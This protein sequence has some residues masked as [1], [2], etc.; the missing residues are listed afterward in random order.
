MSFEAIWITEHWIP[1][2]LAI[3]HLIKEM[4]RFSMYLL[5]SLLWFREV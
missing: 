4:Y 3:C 5:Q 2:T 1:A